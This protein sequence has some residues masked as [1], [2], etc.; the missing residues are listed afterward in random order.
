MAG[1][2]LNSNNLTPKGLP[3]LTAYFLLTKLLIPTCL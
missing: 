3:D 1:Q 2:D